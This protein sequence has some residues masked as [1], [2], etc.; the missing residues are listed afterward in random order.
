M[1]VLAGDGWRYW[2]ETERLND[3]D[4]NL[5]CPNMSDVNA[6]PMVWTWW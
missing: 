5:T 2:L 6:S 4:L 3:V 1:A